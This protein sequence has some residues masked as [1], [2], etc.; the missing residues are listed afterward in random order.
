MLCGALILFG[1]LWTLHGN[2]RE[3]V[4]KRLLGQLLKLEDLKSF[5]L[6]E[7]FNEAIQTIPFV[8]KY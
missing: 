2:N 7:S 3:Y 5:H 1:F 8:A 6:I 4:C